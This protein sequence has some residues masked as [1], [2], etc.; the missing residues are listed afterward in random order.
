M[1][2]QGL[3][4][5][6]YRRLWEARLMDL[7]ESGQTQEQWCLQ[8]GISKSTLKYWIR[9]AKKQRKEESDS[10]KWLKVETDSMLSIEQGNETIASKISV[11]YGLFRVDITR[12]VDSEQIY[13]VLRVIKEL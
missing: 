3:S 13:S 8:N 1:L 10:S 7:E 12:G 2:R 6:E 11:I 5:A 4:P 9:K